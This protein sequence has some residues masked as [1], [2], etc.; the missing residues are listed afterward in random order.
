V[1]PLHLAVLWL[2]ATNQRRRKDERG[3]TAVE[4]M[5]VALGVIV[6]ASIAVV[7]IQTF[8]TNKTN[9]LNSP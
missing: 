5:V 3:Y 1:S 2:R 7:A 6:I 4:W 9:E 8:V